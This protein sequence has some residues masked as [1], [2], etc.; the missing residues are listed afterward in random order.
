MKVLIIVFSII[1]LILLYNCKKDVC[2]TCDCIS[3]QNSDFVISYNYECINITTFDST[4]EIIPYAGDFKNYEFDVDNDSVADFELYSKHSISRS[5]SGYEKSA[6]KI[7]NPSYEISVA[8]FPDTLHKYTTSAAIT[9]YNSYVDFSNDWTKQWEGHDTIISY[10]IKIYPEAYSL[11]DTLTSNALWSN[12]D[13]IL[14]Y[15]DGT[16][17]QMVEPM[18]CWKELYGNWNNQNMK[19]IIFRKK[20]NGK[21]LHGWLR[22]SIDNITEI[23]VYEYAI[24]KT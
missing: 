6:I 3:K 13:L 7:V 19:Y 1:I 16:C 23:R 17:D 10:S 22:L 4:I 14:S 20:N 12:D 2:E 9:Y 18:I 21:D 5:G 8:E 24:Q 11:G 15:F